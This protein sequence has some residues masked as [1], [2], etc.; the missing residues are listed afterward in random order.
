LLDGLVAGDDINLT[1]QNGNVNQFAFD[2]REI[3]PSDSAEVFSQQSPGITVILLGTSGTSRL[4][5]Q[6][7]YIVP[8]ASGGGTDTEVELGEPA[9][10]DNWQITANSTTFLFD[11]PEAPAGF[12]FFLIDFT[13]EN[14]AALQIDVGTLTFSLLD[15][16]G[17]RYALNPVASQFGN[18]PVARG[19]VR[20]GDAVNATAGYQIPASLDTNSL[21]W[22]VQVAGSDNV[23]EVRLPFGSQQT[24]RAA[25]ISV[26]Q[27]EVSLDGTSLVLQGDISN[28]GSEPLVITEGDISLASGGTVYLLFSTTP[29][30][31][32]IIGPGQT[33]P[34][35]L[36]FQRPSQPNAIF[37]VFSYPFELTGLQ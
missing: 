20:P 2:R 32:W 5:A 19:P 11:R 23:L 31:P 29:G 28:L 21:T 6:G 3:V 7:H 16:F 30:F 27:A 4:L 37:S 24:E 13:L 10:L 18:F 9:Q 35:A 33:S 36:Q 8:E 14:L 26:S 22:I 1:S 12:A 34:Y 25:N 15:E 17:N